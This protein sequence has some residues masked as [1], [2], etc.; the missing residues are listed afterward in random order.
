MTIEERYRLAVEALEKIAKFGHTEECT[1]S[2]PVHECGC[3]EK[4]EKELAQE[5]LDKLDGEPASEVPFVGPRSGAGWM[6][7]PLAAMILAVRE[8]KPR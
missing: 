4:N 1:S 8:G 7:L 6:P 2:A 3:Y 5:A